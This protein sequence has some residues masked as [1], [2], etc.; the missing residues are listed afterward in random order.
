MLCKKKIHNIAV[1]HNCLDPF[2]CYTPLG[3]TM[4]QIFFKSIPE[5]IINSICVSLKLFHTPN[6]LKEVNC[7]D[8]DWI[9]QV[10]LSAT[11]RPELQI[12]LKQRIELV[13]AVKMACPFTYLMID[14]LPHSVTLK[15]YKTV[16]SASAFNPTGTRAFLAIYDS[17]FSTSPPLHPAISLPHIT[18][19]KCTQEC[20]VNDELYTLTHQIIQ[21]IRKVFETNST[22]KVLELKTVLQLILFKREYTELHHKIKYNPFFHKSGNVYFD[23]ILGFLLQHVFCGKSVVC[24]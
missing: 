2:L 24:G 8:V 17:L 16:S 13:T 22:G 21:A 23:T 14:A 15:P 9:R 5:C 6:I 19:V 10:L 3:S 11:E 7:F 20:V 1:Q 4:I 18:Y 12:G